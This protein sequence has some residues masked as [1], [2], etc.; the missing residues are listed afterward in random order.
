MV[1]LHDPYGNRTTWGWTLSL[2]ALLTAAIAAILIIPATLWALFSAAIVDPEMRP[3]GYGWTLA[4]LFACPVML[5]MATAVGLG[6][7]FRNVSGCSFAFTF[8]PT[9]LVVAILAVDLGYVRF[10]DWAP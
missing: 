4:M 1:E 7:F 2:C 3:P 8:L 5:I 10:D 6:S 9:F